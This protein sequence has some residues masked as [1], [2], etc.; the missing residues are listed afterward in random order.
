[1]E[2]KHA[3]YCITMWMC[4][5]KDND[6]EYLNEGLNQCDCPKYEA[7]TEFKDYN[8]FRLNIDLVP[9]DVAL[10]VMTRICDWL[11]SGGNLNDNYIKT[12][13]KYAYNCIKTDLK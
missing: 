7:P 12:Q 9:T 1:M 3:D 2:C 13:L 5:L 4:N 11:V 10:D 8:E 6:C